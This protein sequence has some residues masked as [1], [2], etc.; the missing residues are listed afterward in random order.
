MLE[1]SE[2][3][4]AQGE[5]IFGAVIV[6]GLVPQNGPI[7]VSELLKSYD[8]KP[9][10]VTGQ[11]YADMIDR[12]MATAVQQI[13]P[14]NN[15]VW[16]DDGAKIHRSKVAL[17]AIDE[18]QT[19]KLLID[20][21][22]MAIRERRG[23]NKAGIRSTRVPGHHQSESRNKSSM[24]PNLPEPETMYPA[25]QLYTKEVGGCHQD[26]KAT[27]SPRRTISSKNNNM[28]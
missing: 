5:M 22:R 18:W 14:R 13:Y 3:K 9:K 11:I 25:Y 26:K 27:R 1:F 12:K 2:E 24:A 16:Q 15:A 28:K 7:F 17:E 4:F 23:Y 20:G 21:R 19:L 10:S 6:R 8:P